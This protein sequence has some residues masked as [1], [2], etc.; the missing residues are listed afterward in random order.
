MY[1][2]EYVTEC[3]R[4]H[5]ISATRDGV[6]LLVFL[7]KRDRRDNLTIGASCVGGR[8]FPNEY[9]RVVELP[10]GADISDQFMKIE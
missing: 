8:P 6:T 5:F 9:V 2:I 4:Y 7:L 1:S 3:N 10:S